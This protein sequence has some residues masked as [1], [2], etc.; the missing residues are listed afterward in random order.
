MEKFRRAW[1]EINLDN[2]RENCEMIH[3]LLKDDCAMLAVVKA[4]AYG[5][6]DV[7]VAK[8]IADIVDGFAVSNML[9]GRRLRRAGIRKPILILG[10]TPAT[11][12]QDLF[13][14]NLIQT[15]VGMEYARELSE[16]ASKAGVTLEVHMKVD[17]GMSRIGFS[18]VD[19]E[20]CIDDIEKA[21]YLPNLKATGIFTHFA[22]ADEET[23]KESVDFTELQHSRFSDVVYGLSKRGIEFERVHCCN[24]AAIIS[25]PSYHHTMVRAGIIMY[26]AEP[27]STM[28]T[29]L[30]FKPV[31]ALKSVVSMVKNL[32]AGETISYG[33]KYKATE[34]M[35]VATVTIGYADGYPRML[36]NRGYAYVRD[37]V[38]PVVGAVC[39]DQLMLDVTG[40]DVHEGDIVTFFGGDSPISAAN[41]ASMIGTI[42][43]E[44]FCGIGA[45]VERVYLKNGEEIKV[46]DYTTL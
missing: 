8:E 30:P 26:G 25:K 2:L 32:P 5:H 19:S 45:R 29:S 38:V 18:A 3:G 17:T 6:G 42:N 14:L 34:E 4:N 15:V 21:C 44:I 39:M 43:Y 35:Q 1:A 33:R 41:L 20:K 24:S 23:S 12:A 10:Y 16:A 36:S 7:E 28:L 22:V 9:E 13:E 11:Y 37:C 40:L 27:S 46:V 31:M